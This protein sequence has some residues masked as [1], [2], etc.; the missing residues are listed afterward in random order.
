VLLSPDS[1]HAEDH[2]LVGDSYDNS[3]MQFRNVVSPERTLV[4]HP[5]GSHFLFKIEPVTFEGFYP[6]IISKDPDGVYVGQDLVVVGYGTNDPGQ[7][8]FP[9]EAYE[10]QFQV[11]GVWEKGFWAEAPGAGPCHG[12]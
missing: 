4:S 6:A 1:R 2:V 9:G 8:H 10:V 3:S 5:K 7:S 11:A 12:A